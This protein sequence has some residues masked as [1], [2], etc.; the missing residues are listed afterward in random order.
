M[1]Y[2]SNATGNSAPKS[3]SGIPTKY[4]TVYDALLK[5]IRRGEYTPGSRLPTESKLVEQFRVSRITVIRALRDLQSAGVLRRRRG[6]GSYVQAPERTQSPNATAERVGALFLPLEA[7]S[8]FF[9]VH[10][11]LIRAAECRGWHI[12]SREMPL[13]DTPVQ[14][15]RLVED[16]IASEVKGLFYLP[17]PLLNK[18]HDVNHAIAR[19]CVARNLPLVL[20]DRDINLLY[21][22]SMF[23]VVGSDN[24]L[25]GFLVGK[26]LVELGCRRIVFFSDARSHPTTQAREAGV[27]N[28]VI[29]CPRAVCELCSGDGDDAQLIERLL[30]EFKPDAIACV[31]DMTAAKVMRTLLRA[32]VRVPQQIKLTGFDDTTTAALLAVPLTTVRQSAEAMGV[33]GVNIMAQRIVSPQLPAVTTSIACTLVERESTLGHDRAS[34]QR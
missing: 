16:M 30:Y 7:G 1:A 15:A 5:A 19:Q 27:R 11:A 32:G 10:R 34:R 14:A 31:N 25:G 4:S 26:H 17:V 22:R 33:Q 29:L 20:L 21:D 12:L 6:S 13:E 23:D 8:I 3:K 18:G 2:K 28:A 9:D 24:E